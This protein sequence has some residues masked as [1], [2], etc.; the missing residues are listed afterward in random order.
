MLKYQFWDI[1]AIEVTFDEG[2]LSG[3]ATLTL[4]VD[5]TIV[6]QN[7]AMVFS[8]WKYTYNWTIP[9]G[10]ALGEYNVL[11]VGN[12]GWP[13]INKFW[14][15]FVVGDTL[16]VALSELKNSQVGIDFTAFTDSQL[17]SNVEIATDMLEQ[18]LWYQIITEETEFTEK[19]QS[20]VDH[21]WKLLVP[22]RQNPVVSVTELKIKVPWTEYI[23]LGTNNLEIYHKH[24]Y[25]YYNLH[26]VYNAGT[27]YSTIVLNSFDK[28]TYEVT[29]TAWPN[30]KTLFKQALAQMVKNILATQYDFNETGVASAT[31]GVSSFMSGKY[32]VNFSNRSGQLPY[33]SG[34]NYAFLDAV[35]TPDLK[36][37][38]NRYRRRGQNTFI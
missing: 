21:E 27:A 8:N 32:K 18:Y 4:S 5:N 36:A 11:W 15:S 13:S 2:Q 23:D 14:E 3:G 28:Y 29:Y 26:S 38:L 24:W 12:N 37:M 1:V 19:S 25:G 7:V 22:F 35:L 9:N 34:E 30:M 10:S 20:V 16:L 33:V 6:L 31:W 17:T